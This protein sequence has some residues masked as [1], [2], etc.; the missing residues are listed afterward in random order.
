MS[1]VLAR[2]PGAGSP[3][4]LRLPRLGNVDAVGLEEHAAAVGSLA[5]EGASRLRVLELAVGLLEVTACDATATPGSLR[6]VC[7]RAARPGPGVP[8]VAAVCVRPALVPLCC[9]RLDGAGVSVASLVPAGDAGRVAE[10]GADEV[11]IELDA[12]ALLAGRYAHIVDRVARAKSEVGGA[13]LTVIVGTAELG[14]YDVVRR[15][16][17]LAI[18]A[19]VDFVAAAP[20]SLPAA[21][22][23]LEALRDVRDETGHVVGF[24]ASGGLRTTEQAVQQ[25]ALVHETLG[26]EWLA[27]GRY[28]LGASDRLLDELVRELRAGAANV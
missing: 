12:A 9:H 27:P 24:K 4:G 20:A 22:C 2:P 11:E 6:D 3:Y 8:A 16:A 5:V 10:L 19:G 23:V 17:L 7:A 15:A 21:L 1:D 13:P 14:G 18:V 28:R 25:L 26:P